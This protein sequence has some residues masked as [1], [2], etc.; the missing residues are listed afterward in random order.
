MG[1][2]KH[3]Q[4]LTH[5][6]IWD[7]SALVQSWDEAVEEYKLYHSIHAKGENIEDVLK[8]AEAAGLDEEQNF[9]VAGDVIAE[10]DAMEAETEETVEPAAA[11]FTQTT[12]PSAQEKP[13]VAEGSGA[14]IGPGPTFPAG[15]MPMPGAVLPHVQDEN[16]KNLMMSWYFAGYYTGLYEG[17][18]QANQPKS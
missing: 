11:H 10:D 9:C 4:S 3:D 2:P 6:E 14:T 5:E 17:R 1:K 8:E 15:A 18:Q 13:P 16:L 12:E 7:D